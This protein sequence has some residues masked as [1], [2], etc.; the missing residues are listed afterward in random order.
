M[1]GGTDGRHW[2]R[3]KRSALLESS[4]PMAHDGHMRHCL[5]GLGRME[6]DSQSPQP[7]PT[8]Y[9]IGSCFPDRQQ[10]WSAGLAQIGGSYDRGLAGDTPP[11][12]LSCL[13]QLPE[14]FYPYPVPAALRLIR[15]LPPWA[16][17]EQLTAPTQSQAQLLK[18]HRVP[19]GPEGVTGA[20][21]N[22]PLGESGPKEKRT[23]PVHMCSVRRLLGPLPKRQPPGRKYFT[24][25]NREALGEIPCQSAKELTELNVLII[26]AKR[27]RK[28][29][30]PKYPL[31]NSRMSDIPEDKQNIFLNYLGS[32]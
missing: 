7:N 11:E 2:Q 25:S 17:A 18:Q 15:A 14:P 24:V 8:Q 20:L 32:L 12:S 3:K 23:V 31:K 16:Q 27:V 4:L 30:L 10:P 13:L 6:H 19:V 29:P 1:A 5:N 26:N 22:Q 28:D 21:S 9:R